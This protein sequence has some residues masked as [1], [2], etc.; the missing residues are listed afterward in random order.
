MREVL[1]AGGSGA[2][3]PTAGRGC[4]GS[5]RSHGKGTSASIAAD[6]AAFRTEMAGTSELTYPLPDAP[7]PA[8]L[9]PGLQAARRPRLAGRAARRRRHPRPAGRPPDGVRPLPPRRVVADLR[10]TCPAAGVR[11]PWPG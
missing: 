7:G 3:R 6:P 8:T 11:L 1:H 4:R 10:R 2:G 5:W 9:A